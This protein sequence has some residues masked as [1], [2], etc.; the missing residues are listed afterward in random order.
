MGIEAGKPTMA[1]VIFSGF[2]METAETASNP[3]PLDWPQSAV[4][5]LAQAKAASA[6]SGELVKLVMSGI[7]RL[8][9]WLIENRILPALAARDVR[10]LAFD[11]AALGHEHRTAALVP[12]P[13]G[14]ALAC[15]IAGR[16]SALDPQEARAAIQ[17]I[18]FRFAPGDHW[19]RDFHAA[20]QTPGGTP[21]PAAPAEVAAL[22][23]EVTGVRPHGFEAGVL[24]QVQ[25][26]GLNVMD[27]AFNSHGLLGL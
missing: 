12:L 2:A 6:A 14:S 16:W 21:A 22:W 24:D 10:V 15:S 7:R 11:V 25:S 23:Q 3:P 13:D 19:S 17:Y 18:G 26:F 5:L 9:S 1:T 8:D 20:V 27:R 4:G